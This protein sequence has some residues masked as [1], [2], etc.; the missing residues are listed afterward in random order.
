MLG[1]HHFIVTVT[2]YNIVHSQQNHSQCGRNVPCFAKDSHSLL[3]GKPQKHRG[4]SIGTHKTRKCMDDGSWI[5]FEKDDI[6]F[7]GCLSSLKLESAN[8]HANWWMFY[9]D[10]EKMKKHLK[11]SQATHGPPWRRLRRKRTTSMGGLGFSWFLISVWGLK[12]EMLSS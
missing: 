3:L 7:S 9:W 11:Q 6:I 2:I 10:K 1:C 8:Q 4:V 5:W 12:S